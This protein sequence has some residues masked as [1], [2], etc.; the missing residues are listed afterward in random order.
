MLFTSFLYAATGLSTGA[1]AAIAVV[2]IVLVIVAVVIVIVV[3][4]VIKISL[5]GEKMNYRFLPVV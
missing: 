1:I 4:V 2:V 3:V 5:Q